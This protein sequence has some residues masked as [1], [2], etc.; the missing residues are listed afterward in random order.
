MPL[1]SAENLD[2]RKKFL[3]T[4]YPLFSRNNLNEKVETV[5]DDN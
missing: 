3:T 4:N 2:I 1:S 5:H